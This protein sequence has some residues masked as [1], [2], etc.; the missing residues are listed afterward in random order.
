M[1]RRRTSPLSRRSMSML[2]PALSAP[3]SA[4]S[5]LLGVTHLKSPSEYLY[6]LYA[7]L[8]IGLTGRHSGVTIRARTMLWNALP[9]LTLFSDMLRMI[10]GLWRQKSTTRRFVKV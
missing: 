2:L 3:V 8:T 7:R 1:A 6:R 4:W 9:L 5:F 10:V